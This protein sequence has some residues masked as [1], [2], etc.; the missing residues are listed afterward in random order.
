MAHLSLLS[1]YFFLQKIHLFK[2]F[3]TSKSKTYPFRQIKIKGNVFPSIKGRNYHEHY[4]QDK[5]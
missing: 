4:I 2:L 3:W 1:K 5:I